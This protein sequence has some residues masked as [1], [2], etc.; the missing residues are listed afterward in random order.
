MLLI[1]IFRKKGCDMGRELK[2]FGITV[3]SIW[4]GVVQT[5][6]L[7]EGRRKGQINALAKLPAVSPLRSRMEIL[8]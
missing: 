6:L 4:P 7:E 3:C 2:E 8:S 1:K 5:E